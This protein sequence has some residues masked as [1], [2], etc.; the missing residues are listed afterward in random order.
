MDP[1]ILESGDFGG[2]ENDPISHHFQG[3]KRGRKGAEDGHGGNAG[4]N[5]SAMHAQPARMCHICAL[6]AITAH[7]KTSLRGTP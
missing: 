2:S 6:L 7:S 4:E 3:L 1:R 5:P